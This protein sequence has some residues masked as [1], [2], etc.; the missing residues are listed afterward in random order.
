MTSAIDYLIEGKADIAPYWYVRHGMDDRD[1]SF[2]VET[3][4]FYAVRTNKKIEDSD[5]GFAWL[6][7]HSGNYDEQ[8]AY[9]WLRKMIAK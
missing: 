3:V 1:T 2:A 8:E 9:S 4:L 5:T 7:P 6:K